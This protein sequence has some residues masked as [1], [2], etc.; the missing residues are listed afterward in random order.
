MKLQPEQEN[1]EAPNDP[2]KRMLKLLPFL[3]P[4][5][6]SGVI[7]VFLT[8]GLSRD[9]SQIPSP[10][11]GKQVPQFELPPVKGYALGL[12]NRDL[13]GEVALVNV[14]ASWCA[15]CLTEHPILVDLAQRNIVPIHGLNYKDSPD[16]A[17][18]WLKRWGSP[19]TRTGAD[20]SGLVGI[21]WGVYGVPETF[22]VGADGRIAYKHIGPL[23]V[24][25]VREK[26]LP[27]IDDLRQ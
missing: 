7:A 27:M 24:E 8:M 5:V 25:F 2:P 6:L 23:T 1:A 22:V 3:L 17:A 19:Y 11:I 13:I 21:D 12:A 20:V 26:L 9:P 4:L 18:S 14:F 16:D 15:A 10:L